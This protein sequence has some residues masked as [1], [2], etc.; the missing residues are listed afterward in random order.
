M[1][2]NQYPQYPQMPPNLPN[3]VGVP[4]SMQKKHHA[5]GLIIMLVLVV[6]IA[7][8][9]AGFGFWAYGS[10]L[11][12]KN[13][14]DQ[15]SA[16]AVEIAVQQEGTRK[17]AEFTER[18]KEPLKKYLGPSAFGTLEISYPKTWSAY[19][20]EEPRG[21]VPLDGYF[22]PNFVPSTQGGTAFALRVQVTS[23]TYDQELNQF[24]GLVQTGDVRVSPYAPKN[25]A[26]VT[27]SRIDGELTPGKQ[28]SMILLPLRDKTIKIYSESQQFM[29][30]FNSF[31]LANLKF[32][33]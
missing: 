20:V 33:P 11:D 14:S 4:A 1:P 31:I 3:N 23:V 29:G 2:P 26:G 24:D 18:E 13:N 10:M 28:G 15:K 17:D 8:G 27:G 19:V 5:W 30:D 21:G 9:L 32:V 12:Y 16:A 7:L 6:M 22:H 25:V